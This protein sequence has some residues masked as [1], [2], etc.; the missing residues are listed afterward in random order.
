MPEEEDD[1][2]DPVMF[3]YLYLEVEILAKNSDSFSVR[4]IPFPLAQIEV[5]FQKGIMRYM[6]TWIKCNSHRKLKY[7]HPKL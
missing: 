2:I 1:M 7:C 4:I 3:W 6:Y 5:P